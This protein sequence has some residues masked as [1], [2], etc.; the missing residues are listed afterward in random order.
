MHINIHARIF[1]LRTVL[2]GE[3]IRVMT[4]RLTDRGVPPLLVA[5]VE[6][7]LDRLLDRPEVLDERELL[8]RM[9]KELRGVPGFESFV[10][11]NLAR[12]PFAV[13]VKGDGIEELGIDTL[14]AA[15]D[16][17]TTAMAGP[18]AVGKSPFDII[19]ALRLALRTT[20]TQVADELLDQMEPNDALVA[21]MMDIHA[22]DEPQRDRDNFRRQIE[23]TQEAA[24]QRPGR[25]LPFF[26]VHPERADHFSLLQEAVEKRGFLGVKLYPSLGYEVGSPALIRVYEYC[27]EKDLPVLLHCGHGGFYRRE[28]YKD[29]CDPKQWTPVLTEGLAALRVCFAHFGGWESLGREGELEN[30]DSW[31]H[32][33][34]EFMKTLPNVY[35]DLAYHSDQ[36]LDPQDEARYF[37]K[38]AEL[39]RD[40][41]LR[42]RILFGTDSWLLRLDMTDGVYWRYYRQHM[43]AADFDK[44]AG[45][46]PRLFLGFPE[47]GHPIRAN[48]Q[49]YIDYLSDN[50]SDVGADPAAWLLE[51]AG[52]AFEAQRDS[53][54]WSKDSEAVQCTYRL[55]KTFMSSQQAR[56]GYQGNRTTQL[57]ELRYFRPRDPNFGLICS[58]IAA[59]LVGCGHR[60]TDGRYRES[61]GAD[62]AVRQVTAVLNKGEKR[63]VD[64]AGLLDSI[65]VFE[66]A[67]A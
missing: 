40:A 43:T 31:G 5:A 21:L 64:V 17:L 59:D 61:W 1:T 45:R 7:L 20:I 34:L 26:A 23:G 38:L 25:V 33:I 39:L 35:T 66:R 29:Y 54:A 47:D 6:R 32:T 42:D 16:E 62:E 51:A 60:K 58:R 63:L 12:L 53:P 8:A 15:L 11:D 67:L 52:G 55:L 57:K 48:L 37:A 18:D 13:V 41:R 4:Q 65:F 22:R 36:M 10:Q 44:I 2:S 50:R 27:I 14:R 9:L 30:P 19:A 56:G 46:A 28:E 3:A 49:R 24:L